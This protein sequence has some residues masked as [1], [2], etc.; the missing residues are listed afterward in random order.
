MIC[1]EKSAVEFLG[2][3]FPLKKI[4]R[5]DCPVFKSVDIIA[6]KLDVCHCCS[7]LLTI[8]GVADMLRMIE[9]TDGKDL[10]P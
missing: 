7:H 6:Q 3:T 10:N 2:N 4:K 5:M 9:Q 8:K 1:E